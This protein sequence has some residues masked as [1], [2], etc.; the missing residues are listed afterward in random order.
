MKIITTLLLLVSFNA[1]A[2]TPPEVFK[3][4]A[5]SVVTVH[6]FND[7]GQYMNQGSGVAVLDGKIAT[8]C[9]VIQ[10]GAL[11]LVGTRNSLTEAR[12]WG[13]SSEFDVCLLTPNKKYK[14]SVVRGT[15]GLNIG[16]TTYAIGTP[17]RQE[18]TMTMGIVS[19]F[20]GSNKSF[21]QTDAAISSG[22]SGG[23]LFNRHGELIGLTT[24]MVAD[25]QNLN[26]AINADVIKTIKP[27]PIKLLIP[28]EATTEI[29]KR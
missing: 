29:F 22:S 1:F 14:S 28:D 27:G 23:G 2:L 20:R 24:Y 6:V 18:L 8:A 16:D 15:Q 13:G 12:V 9:H 11:V 19:Q 25:G 7:E 26:V 17:K 5:P 21:I 10:R 3:K 4:V